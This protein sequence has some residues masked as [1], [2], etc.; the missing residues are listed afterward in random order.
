MAIFLIALSVVDVLLF[1]A[2]NLPWVIPLS[3][4]ILYAL[5][6]FKAVPEDERFVVE[7]FGR[8]SQ[9]LTPG[10]K[11]IWPW[12]QSVRASVPTSIQEIMLFDPPIKIDFSDGSA[13]P[14][15]AVAQ[16]QLKLNNDEPY[17]IAGDEERHPAYRAIYLV[18]NWRNRTREVLENAVRSQLN[19]ITLNEGLVK[20]GPGIK[21]HERVGGEEALVTISGTLEQIGIELTQITIKD[22]DLEPAL[23]AARGAIQVAAR[24]LEAQRLNA[25]AL[26]QQ[27]VGVLL[28]M[29]SIITGKTPE[30]VSQEINRNSKLKKELMAFA[31]DMASRQTSLQRDALTDIR[32]EGADGLQTALLQAIALLQRGNNGEDK[33][34]VSGNV[35]EVS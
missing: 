2:H 31:T 21:L 30:T 4:I 6:G 29:L 13:I 26:A 32:V 20:N 23:I 27:S 1:K 28:S 14:Q 3:T 7:L 5:P 25:Q 17:S 22:F 11:W 19:A 24:N 9:I 15:G 18:S 34:G 33:K 12:F 10:L 35:S 8:F 16:V